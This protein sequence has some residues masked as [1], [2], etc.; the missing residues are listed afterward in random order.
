MD[1]RTNDVPDDLG[2]LTSTTGLLLVRVVKLRNV[3]ARLAECH[4]RFARG[5]LA[6][7]LALHALLH[8]H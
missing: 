1:E 2:V 6:L 4:L 8:R 3:L 5:H 7:V